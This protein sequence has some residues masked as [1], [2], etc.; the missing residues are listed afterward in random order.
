M[1][2][3]NVTFLALSLNTSARAAFVAAN[4]KILPELQLFRAV[5][6]FDTRQTIAALC[7]SGLRYHWGYC[8][9]TRF[10]T[11]GSLANYLTKVFAIAHQ[12]SR[13]LPVMAMLEDDM[14]LEEGFKA[15]VEAK[16][17]SLL[18]AEQLFA[19]RR[20]SGSSSGGAI[21]SPSDLLALGTWGEGYVTTLA[22]ARRV[23]RSFKRQGVPLNVDIMINDGHVGRVMRIDSAERVP[24]A[25]RVGA[26]LGDC[27]RTPHIQFSELPSQCIAKPPP[28]ARQGVLEWVQKRRETYC[29]GRAAVLPRQEPPRQQQQ[30][31]QLTRQH[32][33][34]A[35][36]H[37]QP[38]RVGRRL[39]LTGTG[40]RASSNRASSSR[41][42]SSR[43]SSSRA[44]SSR[45]GGV[46]SDGGSSDSASSSD[47]H[48]R[49]SSDEQR[50]PV[51]HGRVALVLR[52][53]A[54]RGASSFASSG[55]SG[56]RG[57]SAY[58]DLAEQLEATS[59]VLTKLILPLEAAPC[60][61][62]VDVVLT[63]CSVRTGCP[64]IPKLEALLGAR[65]VA[66]TT[67][68]ASADQ[69]RNVRMALEALKHA[70]AERADAERGDSARRRQAGGKQGGSKQAGSKAAG[71]VHGTAAHL[72]ATAAA[73]S[74]DLILLTR[75]D[76][77]W[78]TSITRW[79]SANF[80]RLNF[81]GACEPRCAGCESRSCA[82]CP[83]PNAPGSRFGGPLS[84][85]VQDLLH[86]V[87]GPAFP[88][89][90]AA[91]GRKG[92]R[93]FDG[94]SRGSGHKCLSA[95][96]SSL[97]STTGL[98]LPEDTWRPFRD[99]REP[100]PICHYLVPMGARGRLGNASGAMAGGAAT[101]ASATAATAQRAPCHISP[102][103]RMRMP[104]ALQR[105]LCGQRELPT[106]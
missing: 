33:Q 100:N 13:Q 27:L 56:L 74:Y 55:P 104:I 82:H 31:Q 63:E 15:F 98:V 19:A 36:Q 30:Q 45:V 35:R 89:F 101:S 37:Q 86:L 51:S 88:A 29:R 57:C 8:G 5:N 17:A 62:R 73:S 58:A 103:D 14:Q 12:V 28:L 70:A 47:G 21:D 52:G 97:G 38:R 16:A 23:L 65:V 26:N 2:G 102:E 50:C 48:S 75:H 4:R 10:G 61:N 20:A 60:H 22:S 53:Q 94:S 80:T 64:L 39:G 54:F 68:C 9:F 44:S 25:H 77:V 6:G 95:V 71:A 83:D 78:T 59:S 3:G 96:E 43:A 41:A 32:Q 72:A 85:C 40:S 84:R 87:P 1:P 106:R 91:V 7:S 42:S 67:K 46:N 69:P 92:S 79:R 24:W 93:C 81:L 49:G 76:V 99:V 18:H 11:F 66:T 105:R 90:D 34:L